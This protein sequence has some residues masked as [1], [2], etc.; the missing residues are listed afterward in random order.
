VLPR[1]VRNAMVLAAAGALL[2]APLAAKAADPA[3]KGAQTAMPLGSKPHELIITKI[4]VGD[5]AKSL[6]FYTRI[7]GLKP[8]DPD[9]YEASRTSTADFVEIGLNHAG[10][11]AEAALMLIRR[12]GDTP[13]RESAR[14]TW[15]AFKA[16]DVAAAIARIKAEGYEIRNE[17]TPHEDLIFGIAYDPDGYTVEFLS[18]R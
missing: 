5:L 7:V 11:R 6:D 2:A 18:E 15:V 17:A 12:K 13:T 10:K 9:K 14:R 1:Y 8:T 16:P 4:T 3:S